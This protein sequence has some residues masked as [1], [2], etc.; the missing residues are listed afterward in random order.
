MNLQRNPAVKNKVWDKITGL[1][2]QFE[3]EKGQRGLKAGETARKRLLQKEKTLE[4]LH[5]LGLENL[6]L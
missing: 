5:S 3:E 6:I 1:H 2:N 4:D